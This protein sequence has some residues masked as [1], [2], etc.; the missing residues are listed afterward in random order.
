M[1]RQS[2]SLTPFPASS[3]PPIAITGN[4]SRQNNVL[5]LSYSLVG[6]L[7]SILMPS[8]SAHP[9]RKDELWKA[10]CF[11][12]FLALKDQPQYWEFNMSPSGDW[13]VYHMDTY[14]RVGFRE[15]TSIRW[16]QFEVKD[17][18]EKLTLNVTVDLSPIIQAAQSLDVGITAVIQTRDGDETYWALVHPASQADFH[19]RESFTLALAG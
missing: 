11:E 16:L 3:I 10:T 17:E 2:F 8:P 13:N 7:E 4:L 18:V 12:F 15:E 19:L 5:A 1:T 6:N 9:A 14:R